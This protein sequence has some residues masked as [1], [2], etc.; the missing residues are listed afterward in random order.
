MKIT[1]SAVAGLCMVAST[2]MSD[3][4]GYEPF[5]VQ[6]PHHGHGMIGAIWY[7]STGDGRA[8]VFADS[9]VFHG[10]TV[11]EEATLQDGI[12]P[13]VLLSHGMGG[14][15]RSL[16]WLATDLAEQ[17]AIVVAVNHPNSTWGDFDMEAGLQH[18]TRAQDL[19]LALDT[20]PVSD[21]VCGGEIFG[22]CIPVLD[23]H[24][25]SRCGL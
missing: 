13:V 12:H 24:E 14:N 9:A 15:I 7:P 18:W 3:P 8:F 4:A 21:R 16:T 22:R 10:V 25:G 20:F 5:G 17:G 11:V 23:R 6:A 2:A 1:V 19:S